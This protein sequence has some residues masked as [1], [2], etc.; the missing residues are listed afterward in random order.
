MKPSGVSVI[1][2][3]ENLLVSIYDSIGGAPA[4]RVAVDDFYTRVL[5]TRNSRRSS[6]MPTGST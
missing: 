4:G 2:R 1:Y 5:L 3:K 6:L